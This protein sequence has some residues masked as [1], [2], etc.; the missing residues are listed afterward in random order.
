[1][2]AGFLNDQQYLLT[3]WYF[4]G[5][6]KLKRWTTND[7]Q[8]Q[9]CSFIA[10]CFWR[11]ISLLVAGFNPIEKYAK[12]KF[13]HL[14]RDRVENK[15]TNWKTT[16]YQVIQAVTSLSP[17]VGMFSRCFMFI[18]NKYVWEI[19]AKGDQIEHAVFGEQKDIAFWLPLWSACTIT[20]VL[21]RL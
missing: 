16:T 7:E 12:V 14:P 4:M 8:L 9:D 5:P 18:S 2:N 20:P 3:F 21:A 13:H 17:N 1:M 10:D 19:D 15:Q 11:V 6:S